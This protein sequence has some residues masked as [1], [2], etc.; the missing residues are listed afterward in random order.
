MLSGART[1]CTLS[2]DDVIPR[3]R[4]IAR[5][6]RSASFCAKTLL[7]SADTRARKGDFAWL[8][9]D[10][11][12]MGPV[13]IKIGQILS[14]RPDVIPYTIAKQLETL[15]SEVPPESFETVCQVF[16]E[17]MGYEIGD[18]FT[19]VDHVP[20]ASASIGQVHRAVY[21]GQSVVIKVQRPKVRDEYAN[22]LDAL[23]LIVSSYAALD[24]LRSDEAMMVLRDLRST[25]GSETDFIV[26][27]RNMRMFRKM[28]E[29]NDSVVVPRVVK[30]LCSTRVLTMEYLPSTKITDLSESIPSLTDSDKV[31]ISQE[32]LK[33]FVDGLVNHGWMHCDPHPG[34]IG[35]DASGRIVMYD[36]GIV[37]HVD[38]KLRSAMRELLLSA[39]HRSKSSFSNALIK[40]NLVVSKRGG[41][42]D[43]LDLIVLDRLTSYLFEYMETLD[44]RKFLDR[45]LG[46]DLIDVEA[47]P[48]KVNNELF[49]LV[50]SFGVLEG[51]CRSVS[52]QFQY[53]SMVSSMM[54]DMLD[55]QTLVDKVQYDFRTMTQ[56]SSAQGRE[57]LSNV[58]SVELRVRHMTTQMERDRRS[59]KLSLVISVAMYLAT[60]IYLTL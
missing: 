32:L 55:I 41:E 20:L 57:T 9:D 54:F 31:W 27:M 10:L 60:V 14:S 53:T 16:R 24:P 26:E 18:C 6:A 28:F 58:Q 21:K 59:G 30:P 19:Q 37:G 3:V 44:L 56:G 25:L 43:S 8:S 35:I 5:V 1:R 50:R 36:F 22:E 38:D 52:P 40:G 13:Y 39:Y 42:I 2:R 34:N 7:R 46:D 4:R 23:E 33:S 48:F 12:A 11:V 45:L 49:F 51:V 17:D 15:Q 47:L 29:D